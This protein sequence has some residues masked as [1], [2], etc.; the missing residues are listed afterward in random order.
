MRCDIPKTYRWLPAAG[1]HGLAIR[2]KGDTPGW[3][4]QYPHLPPRIYVP[5]RQVMLIVNNRYRLTVR[6]KHHLRNL[7]RISFELANR[8]PGTPAKQLLSV[9]FSC[10]DGDQRP[11]V[12]RES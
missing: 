2:C 7:G 9:F 8:L 6:R 4:I 10:T 3:L 11:P 12:G 1:N 5:E